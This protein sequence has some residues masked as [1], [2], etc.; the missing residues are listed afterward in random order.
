M[1]IVG[2]GGEGVKKM[3]LRLEGKKDK[4]MNAKKKGQWQGFGLF[5]SS[6]CPEKMF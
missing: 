4:L 3:K 5:F 6:S 2:S 1:V